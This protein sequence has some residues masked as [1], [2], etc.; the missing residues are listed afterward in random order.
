MS[1]AA[2]PLIE[3]ASAD[4][5]IA[6]EMTRWLSHLGAERRLSPKTLEAY[7]RD[8]RQCLDFLSNHWGERV[9]LSRFA[10]LEATDIR[11][12]MAMRRADDIAGRSLMRALAGLRS[13]G[14]FLEREGKGK[15][16][17]LSAIRAPKVAKTLP[18]PL[19]MASAKRLA[20]ADE[21]AGEERETWVLARDAAVMAL[22]YGSGLRIS[23]ALGLKRREVPRPGEGDVL[24]VTGKGNKTRMVPVLQNVLALVQ[25]YVAM[26]PY[27]LPAEGPIFLGARG[28]PL[29]PRI[30]QLAMERLRG[31]LGLPDSATPHALRH[32]FATHL[33]SRG[34]DLRAIQ[35]LL[36]HSSLSTTQIYTGID[37]ER[38]LEVYASAHPRR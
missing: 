32:S 19:P 33:L 36:G 13:F 29:S 8:L 6:Q 26:C 12:F 15:V 21:R 23:E 16:G 1:K 3:L 10:A 27:P 37:S 7:G 11:A 14:R 18:K 17:A 28:G 31:A 9:T 22:L 34:G 25:E 38:L 24:I 30:I 20:D 5:S 35:E 2:A 4:P